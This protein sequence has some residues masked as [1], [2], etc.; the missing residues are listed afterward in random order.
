MEEKTVLSE[1]VKI[2]VIKFVDE[3]AF[4]AKKPFETI[5]RKVE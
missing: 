3:E 2:R 1:V 4:K 5:E